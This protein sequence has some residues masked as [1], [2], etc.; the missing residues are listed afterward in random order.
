MSADRE[1]RKEKRWATPGCTAFVDGILDWTWRIALA[2]GG[3]GLALAYLRY[4]TA[5]PD[6][7]TAHALNVLLSLAL[8]FGSLAALWRTWRR[9]RPRD[10]RS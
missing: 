5:H 10:G 1:L 3:T 9:R 2:V 8:I 7:P 6:T 4:T